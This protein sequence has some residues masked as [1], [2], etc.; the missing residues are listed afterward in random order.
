MTYP[1]RRETLWAILII[2]T[3]L[4]DSKLMVYVRVQ[5]VQPDLILLLVVFF[6]MG[7]APER[8]MCTGFLGGIF[9]D[10]SGQTGLGHHMLGLVI[11]GYAA[12]WIS[13]R[14]I[15]DRPAVKGSVVLGAAML[16]G[17]ILTLVGYIQNPEM[18]A[19]YVLGVHV[20]PGAFYTALATPIAFFILERTG[21]GAAHAHGEAG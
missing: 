9:Q 14:L 5:G 7:G 11:V 13:Q 16:H 1:V 19:L 2:V 20:V 12:G 10:V 15:T 18:G 6:A 21:A 3:A 8:A 17:V 4:I